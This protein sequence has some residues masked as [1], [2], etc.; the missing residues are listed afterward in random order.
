MVI[1]EIDLLRVRDVLR[2]GVK[3]LLLC[4][5]VTHDTV[6][7]KDVVPHGV[8]E[9]RI[10]SDF[11]VVEVCVISFHLRVRISP[12]EEVKDGIK[13]KRVVVCEIVLHPSGEVVTGFVRA[14]DR[15]KNS[16]LHLLDPC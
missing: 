3:H 9:I 11:I 2:E 10:T 1:T 4:R 8:L 12:I 16:R 6:N 13:V 15:F 7:L 5:Y 14:E